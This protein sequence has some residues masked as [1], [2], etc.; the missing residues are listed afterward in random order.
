MSMALSL[1]IVLT[2]QTFP[3]KKKPYAGVVELV[4]AEDSKSSGINALASSNL[5][6]GTIKIKGFGVSA[7]TLLL[8]GVRHQ[9]QIESGKDLICHIGSSLKL[10]YISVS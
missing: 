3:L 4:D 7:N 6:S 9:K 2:N 8:L 5:A 10:I 1:I